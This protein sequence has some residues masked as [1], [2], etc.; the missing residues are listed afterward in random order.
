MKIRS[1]LS[2]CSATICA[3]TDEINAIPFPEKSP[4]PPSKL[5]FTDTSG[6][7]SDT[8]T[9]ATSPSLDTSYSY[10]SSLHNYLSLQTLPSV[11]SLQNLSPETLSLAVSHGYLTSIK[12]YPAA[13]VNFLAVYKHLLYAASG[14][15]DPSMEANGK[16]TT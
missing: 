1:L 12:P 7:I 15:Q 9:V 14:Q 5:L 3:A 16:Q 13:H 2:T 4:P 11:P 6:S 8:T 10:G